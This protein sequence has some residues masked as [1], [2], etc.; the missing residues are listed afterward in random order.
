MVAGSPV[1]DGAR[2]GYAG[3]MAVKIVALL[4]LA[5]LILPVLA[6]I[7]RLRNLPRRGPEDDPEA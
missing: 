2:A 5:V 7:G 3:I 6:G 1:A 4:L